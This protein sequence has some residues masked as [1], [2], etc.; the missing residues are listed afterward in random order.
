MS[1]PGDPKDKIFDLMLKT[2]K[3]YRTKTNNG[4]VNCCARKRKKKP[5]MQS[6]GG[7]TEKIGP[8]VVI[9]YIQNT[10]FVQHVEHMSMG[11]SSSGHM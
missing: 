5:E 11:F 8:L 3:R 7:P 10:M 4:I 1:H 6:Q 2:L 9:K